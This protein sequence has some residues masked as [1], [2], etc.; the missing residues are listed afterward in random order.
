[1]A[2]KKADAEIM[3]ATTKDYKKLAKVAD[4][5]LRALERLSK[6]NNPMYSGIK[7]Y[8]YKRAQSDL[9]RWANRRRVDATKPLRFDVKVSSQKELEIRL[10]DVKRFLLSETSTLRGVKAL[11]KNQG[12]KFREEYGVNLSPSQIVNY[13]ATSRADKYDAMYGSKTALKALG[14]IQKT[15]AKTVAQLKKS[16]DKD[17]TLDDDVVK[18]VAEDM[19]KHHKQMTETILG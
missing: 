5:R 11:Y 12:K 1:M 7:Q 4:E 6:Q 8:A 13:F 9:G 18:R 17:K 2:K 10:A 19:L 16:M 3:F 15:K 14:Y